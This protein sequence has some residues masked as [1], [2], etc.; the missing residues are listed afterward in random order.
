M[1]L[2]LQNKRCQHAWSKVCEVCPQARQHHIIFSVSSS[3]TSR[4]F[5]LIHCD[6]WGHCR[7][8]S[9]CDVQC[10]F[11]FV[12]DYTISVPVYFSKNESEVCSG[13]R[14]FLSMIKRQFDVD[15]KF[16]TK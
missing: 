5:G 4:M 3:R 12:D 8:S 11:S 1:L 10:I 14:S 2:A 7:T 6:L 15:V 16:G 13:F 9:S